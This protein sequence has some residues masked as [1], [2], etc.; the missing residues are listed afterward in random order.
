MET[1]TTAARLG[2]AIRAKRKAKGLS[3]EGFADQIR[4]HRA[5]FAAIERGE[6]NLTVGTLMRVAE[7]L[8]LSPSSLFRAAGL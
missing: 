3:Q 8:G 4:M 7:G 2:D 6:K 1:Q 5:Y